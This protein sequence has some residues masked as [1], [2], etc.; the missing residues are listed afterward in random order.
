MGSHAKSVGS[1]WD[2][3]KRVGSKLDNAK[4]AGSKWEV[5]LKVLRVN[6]KS[7]QNCGE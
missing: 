1:K 2:N 6:G 7:C 5:I 4:S 3:A